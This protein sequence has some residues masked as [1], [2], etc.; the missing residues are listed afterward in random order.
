M[1]SLLILI[2]GLNK[3]KVYLYPLEEKEHGA[4]TEPISSAD[5]DGV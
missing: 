3:I 1:V 2:L 4:E 5:R